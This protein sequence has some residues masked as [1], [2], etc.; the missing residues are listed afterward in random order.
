MK[1]ELF[2]KK[3]LDKVKSPEN[4]DDYIRVASPGIW[5]LLVSVIVLLAGAIVWGIFGHVDST[6]ACTVRIENGTAVCYIPEE[7]VTS[8]REGMTVRFDGG[9][10]VIIGIEK[11]GSEYIGT[12]ET[13]DVTAD[14]I[15]AGKI[16]VESIRPLSFIVN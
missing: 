7:S 3:T 9:E 15:H 8:V 2:R 16:V 6:A 13:D 1:E 10:A 14:G 5:L 12:L 11:D 4:M